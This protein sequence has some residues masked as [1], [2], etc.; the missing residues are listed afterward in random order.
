MAAVVVAEA[1]GQCRAA[2]NVYDV[3]S[4]VLESLSIFLFPVLGQL[5]VILSVL[6]KSLAP[7][8]TEHC[9]YVYYTSMCE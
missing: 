5:K 9:F 4:A 6:V 8:N 1:V 2:Q 7:G 3:S